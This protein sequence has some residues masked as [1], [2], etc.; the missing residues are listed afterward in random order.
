MVIVKRW[1]SKSE[2]VIF[3]SSV[4]RG[5]VH[6]GVEGARGDQI[7]I[8]KKI[9]DLALSRPWFLKSLWV[10]R[11]PALWE[12]G[13]SCDLSPWVTAD[14]ACLTSQSFESKLSKVSDSE[15]E[16]SEGEREEKSFCGREETELG[17]GG[18]ENNSPEIGLFVHSS[19]AL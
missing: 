13:S 17:C 2:S 4:W 9:S 18:E 10:L 19:V 12:P 15:R 7:W 16:R 6:L 11:L 8:K 1:G 3:Q 5:W 14:Q